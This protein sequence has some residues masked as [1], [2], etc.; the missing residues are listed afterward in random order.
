MSTRELARVCLQARAAIASEWT[1]EEG[2]ERA[3]WLTQSFMGLRRAQIIDT[4]PLAQEAA[5][6]IAAIMQ[7]HASGIPELTPYVMNDQVAAGLLEAA[8]SMPDVPFGSPCCRGRAGSFGLKVIISACR[9]SL[10]A[11]LM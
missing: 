4:T 10:N 11:Q 5:A 2:G 6:N 8:S 1:T 7:V 9:T 3:I